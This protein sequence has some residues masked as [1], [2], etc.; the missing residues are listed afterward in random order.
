MKVRKIDSLVIYGYKQQ[1]QNFYKFSLPHS[2]IYPLYYITH[3][4]IIYHNLNVMLIN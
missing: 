4:I 2:K 1:I 3:L